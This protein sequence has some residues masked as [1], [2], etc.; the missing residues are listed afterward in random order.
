MSVVETPAVILHAFDYMETS[1]ILRMFTRQA[2]VQSVL[3]RG[4]RASKR[5]FGGGA[6]LDLFA[7][8]EAQYH[9]KPGRELHTLSG[10]D[11]TRARA[12]LALDIGRFTA[13]S[14]LAE[15]IL[16]FARDDA[17]P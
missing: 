16:R 12:A 9:E 7:E 8:G 10:F 13:A 2:G 1:R 3:A 15:L 5:R 6:A 14:V 17:Q 4:A 11:L